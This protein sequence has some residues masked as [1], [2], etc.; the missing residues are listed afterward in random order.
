MIRSTMRIT[1]PFSPKILPSRCDC[2]QNKNVG[3]LRLGIGMGQCSI[4]D[5]L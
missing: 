4:E 1:L 2:P 5:L 3:A